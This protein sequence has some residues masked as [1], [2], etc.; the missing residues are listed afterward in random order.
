MSK[1]KIEVELSDHLYH[2]YQR[3]AERTGKKM[4]ELVEKLVNTLLVEMEQELK[5]P[6]L[7]A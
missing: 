3:E 2:A 7:W 1:L 6:P 4:E 5:D